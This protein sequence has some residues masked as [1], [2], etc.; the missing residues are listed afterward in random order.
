MRFW[1]DK[2][3]VL[4]ECKRPPMISESLFEHFDEV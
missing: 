4:R 1:V 3:V 2:Y